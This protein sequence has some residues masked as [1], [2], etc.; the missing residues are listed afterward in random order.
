MY[1]LNENYGIIRK[2]NSVMRIKGIH[3]CNIKIEA[4]TADSVL[5]SPHIPTS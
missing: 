5:H 4:F 3:P 2:S 1:Y